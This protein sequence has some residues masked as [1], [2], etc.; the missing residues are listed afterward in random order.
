MTFVAGQAVTADQLNQLIPI[1]VAK[2]LDE[3]VNNSAALQDDDDLVLPVE[4][5]ANYLVEIEI[6]YSSGTT[7]D[8]KTTLTVPSG[9]TGT[10]NVIAA[11][12][13]VAG[14]GP[15]TLTGTVVFDGNAASAWGRLFG[16]VNVGST[17]GSIQFRWAQNTANASNTI[18]RAGSFMRLT[19]IL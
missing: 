2:P 5:S 6:V 9:T 13:S 12:A 1:V 4:A 14:A 19:R 3:T 8:L 15:V 16:E 10:L 17:A 11:G 7:P 18:V